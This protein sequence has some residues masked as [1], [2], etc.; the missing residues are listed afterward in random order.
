MKKILIFLIAL[1]VLGE[2]KGQVVVPPGYSGFN[3]RN[4]WLAGA[5]NALNVPSGTG[6]TLKTGQWVRSGALY[7][8]STGVDKGLYVWDGSAWLPIGSATA[9]YGLSQISSSTLGFSTALRDSIMNNTIGKRFGI[10]DTLFNTY[11][12]VTMRNQARVA[13]QA[14][15][16]T[17]TN[18][19]SDTINGLSAYGVSNLTGII[20][21]PFEP[22][23]FYLKKIYKEAWG[24]TLNLQ[25]GGI[26]TTQKEHEFDTTSTRYTTGGKVFAPATGGLFLNSRFYMHRDHMEVFAGQDGNA[27][28][29]IDLDYAF[30]KSWGYNFHV[31]GATTGNA[32]LPDYPL[33]PLN[34]GLD[35]QRTNSRTR[36]RIITGNGV[37]GIVIDEKYYQAD[38]TSATPENGNYI[39]KVTG[40]HLIGSTM[41]NIG[42]T[43][44]KAKIMLVSK[45]DTSTGI[46]IAPRY[47]EGNEIWNGIGISAEGENDFNHFAGYLRVKGILPTRDNSLPVANFENYGTSYFSDT[48]THAQSLLAADSAGYYIAVK[49]RATNITKYVLPENLPFGGATPT[50]QQ[51]FDTQTGEALLTKQ[52][53]IN[54]NNFDFRFNNGSARLVKIDNDNSFIVYDNDDE[55]ILDLRGNG[56]GL[57]VIGNNISQNKIDNRNGKMEFAHP[58]SILW[59]QADGYYRFDHMLSTIDTTTYKPFAIDINGKVRRGNSWA[60]FMGAGGGSGTFV[61]LTDG[62]GAYA[63]QAGKGVRV[64]VTEDGLEYVT[65]SGSGTVTDV[66][67][68]TLGTTGTDLSSSVANGTTT[69]VITLNV[70]T[71]SAANR[72]ALSAADWTTFNAKAPTASPTFATSIT[73]SYLTASEILITDGSKNIVSAP[74][75]TYPSL[76][77]LAFVKGLTSNAQ[78]QIDAKGTG[79]VTK[80]GTP[81]N[82]QVGYWTGDGTAA[83]TNNFTWN[84][85]ASDALGLI[86]NN[87][88]RSTINIQNTNS[89]GQASLLASN[90]RA[91]LAAYSMLSTYGSTQTGNILGVARADMGAL[92]FDGSSLLGAAIAVLTDDPFLIGTNNLERIRVLGNGSTGFGVAAATA[93]LHL[94]AGTTAAST[95][96]LKF[97]SGPLLTSKEVGAWGFLTDKLHFTIT[98]GTAEKEVTLNDIALTSGRVPYVTTNGRLTDESDFLWSSNRLTV[99]DLTITDL[100]TNNTRSF[101]L[102]DD[103]SGGVEKADLITVS[104]SA[105][106]DSLSAN[107]YTPTVTNNPASYN[108]NVASS[109]HTKA[110]FQQIGTIVTVWGEIDVSA[111]A[112]LTNTAVAITLPIASNLAAVTDVTGTQCNW[113]ITT[114]NNYQTF[115]GDVQGD[116]TNDRA[117]ITFNSHTT[118]SL[119]HV[120]YSFSY[121]VK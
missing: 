44:T 74:V 90:N 116:A 60:Q 23:M 94:K 85:T 37:A 110:Q 75:A 12:T 120:K 69:P 58:D 40:I 17:F 97:N 100:P 112:G 35:F 65:L 67:A 89:A 77:Q 68:L 87:S 47:T 16:L 46:R 109:T 42:S 5:F 102:V 36:Q 86:G 119:H 20:S 92:V 95:A 25:Y 28:A 84:Q 107:T 43:T 79:N 14:N 29:L 113:N 10:E 108:S 30:G 78:T 106:P 72:G 27:G 73:G 82:T 33:H 41:A 34:I 22:T 56:A 15:T 64:N 50:L 48:I 91:S 59:N 114:G 39:S 70:P 105:V 49:N 55:S 52:D 121:Q 96:F 4:N 18:A 38:I 2:V 115:D 98:T 57:F 103:G 6:A 83:G 62:P 81:A 21:S 80:V 31:F 93:V 104:Q 71:A 32:P 9:G 26:I 54:I 111:T 88:T 118:T 76:A 3:S 101:F 61:G 1:I 66:A 99:P 45:V 117:I 8:D 11:R 63:G 7:Y 53:T 13:G 51:V 19:N 24:D